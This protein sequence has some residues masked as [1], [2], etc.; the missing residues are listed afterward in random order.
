MKKNDDTMGVWNDPELE[1]RVVAML[2]GELSDFETAELEQELEK[3]PE[4]RLFRDRMLEVQGLINEVETQDGDDEEWKLAPERRQNLLDSFN[5]KPELQDE[6]K[7]STTTIQWKNIAAVAACA[8]LTLVVMAVMFPVKFFTRQGGRQMDSEVVTY[9]ATSD[10][11]YV[12]GREYEYSNEYEPPELP[13]SVG[14]PKK[15][16]EKNVFPETPS[17]IPVVPRQPSIGSGDLAM[18]PVEKEPI[19]PKPIEPLDRAIAERGRMTQD[20]EAKKKSGFG[21][22]LAKNDQLELQQDELSS[23]VESK[24]SAPSS[25]ITKV[26]GSNKPGA[27]V[28]PNPD[29]V[30]EEPSL[31]FGGGDDFGDGWGANGDGSGG[32]GRGELAEI[33]K[34]QNEF[35][36]G[37]TESSKYR[38][39]VYS[40]SNKA[41]LGGTLYFDDQANGKK[42]PLYARGDFS[43]TN[44]EKSPLTWNSSASLGYDGDY[45]PLTKNLGGLSKD[46]SYTGKG[47]K[48]AFIDPVSGNVINGIPS[49]AGQNVSDVITG[50]YR[51]GDYAITRDSIDAFLSNPNRSEVDRLSN[52]TPIQKELERRKTLMLDADKNYD[53]GRKAYEQQNYKESHKQLSDALNRLPQGP[54]GA[55]RKDAYLADLTKA[56]LE[57]SKQYRREGKT[58]K[59]KEVVEGLLFKDK[60]N[61]HLK[62]ELE[63]MNDPIRTSP[64]QSLSYDRAKDVEKVSKSLTRAESYYNQAQFDHA[65]LEYE[66][67]LRLDPYNTDARRGIQRVKRAQNDYYRSA[68]DHTRSA[69]LMEVDKAW[70]IAVV[71]KENLK[72]KNEKPR[73]VRPFKEEVITAKNNHSTFSLNVSDVSFELAKAA[74]LERGEMPAPNQ[75]RVEEFINA[76]DY[77]DPSAST[78]DKVACAIEQCA[79]PFYQQRNLMRVSMKTASMGRNQP[80]KLTILLDN[81]GSME[82]ED[83]ELTVLKAMQVLATQLGPQD[84]ITLISF[85]RNPRLVADSLKGNKAGG[86][87]KLIQAIP[88]EG[89][90]NL[91]LALQSARK[92]TKARMKDG[93]MSRIILITD[94]AANLGNAN[95]DSLLKMV[96]EMR[97]EGIAFDACGVGAK[98]LNDDV[99]EALTRKGDGRYYFINKPEDANANFAQKV[100][101]ALRPAAQNVKV[102]VVF[103]TKRVKKH[104]LLGFEKHRLK[105]E[106]FRNDKVDA[107]EMAANES[108][109]ALYQMEVDPSGTGE[110]GT[111]F[112]RF[113]DMST[114]RMVERSWT[115]PYNSQAPRLTQA[116]PSLQLASVA[117]LLGERLRSS[118]NVTDDIQKLA[119][120]FGKL[121][122][123]YHCDKRVLELIR[124]CELLKK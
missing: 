105:K 27:V 14:I 71:P 90:T 121:R 91:S 81:S 9:N 118:K 57:L 48:T 88:S 8:M 50:G 7:I 37:N 54:L 83:R 77:G 63:Y 123:H 36:G 2:M 100:A 53:A 13:S 29:I 97:Q 56:T 46:L 22:D 117:G 68:Y 62:K 69:M 16:K 99:L 110:V 6:Q 41:V 33:E 15:G 75:V 10:E 64:S 28:I 124:M 89:G 70:E 78:K 85:A 25:S 79:H 82:R 102:Q 101:G 21:N 61:V 32:E 42:V 86:L 111:V 95:P 65:T 51:S 80:L 23:E 39:Q 113:R 18:A 108:G 4:L 98:D 106:D 112:V 60:D 114:G 66:E 26:I 122:T 45:L 24:P 1:A 109:N 58:D 12:D 47:K 74:M 44:T 72:L 92:V 20:E 84:E 87:V 5:E 52:L 76:F 11:S 43:N 67:A 103:N 19:M 96:E 104:K 38:P 107:A 30:V 17:D 55:E 59:A 73:E 34:E 120:L 49:T 115:I 94:G 35:L 40:N 116:E 119:P 93:S 3:S 31:S